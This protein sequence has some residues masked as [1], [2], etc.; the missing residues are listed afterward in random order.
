MSAGKYLIINNEF[1]KVIRFYSRPATVG[2]I[3]YKNAIVE[4]SQCLAYV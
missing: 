1:D 2:I 3:C 4:I